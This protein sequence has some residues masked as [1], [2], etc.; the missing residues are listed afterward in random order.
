MVLKR[1]AVGLFGYVC[2]FLQVFHEFFKAPS[3]FG[4]TLVEEFC[5]LLQGSA[6]RCQGVCGQPCRLDESTSTHSH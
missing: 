1:L 5:V 2:A 4:G 6:P 3:S